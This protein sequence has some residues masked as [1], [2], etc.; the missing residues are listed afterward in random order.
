MR[1][2]HCCV[3]GG[4]GFLGR[5]LL[6]LLVQSGREIT[7]IGRSQSPRPPLPKSVRYIVGD[8]GEKHFLSA[9][10]KGV[11]EVVN[12]AYQTNPKSS[13]DKPLTDL[14]YNL[15]SFLSF[16]QVASRFSMVK[17]VVVSSGG[18]VYGQGG[19][20]PIT[21]D[22]PTNPIS[23]YGVSKLALEKYALMFHKEFAL[24]VV[25]VRPGNAFGEGQKPFTGQGFIATALGCI[26]TGRPVEIFGSEGT[27]RDYI[28]VSDVASGILRA[29]EHGTP[30]G[31]YNIG[32]GVGRSNIDVLNIIGGLAPLCNRRWEIRSMPSRKFDVTANVLDSTKLKSES[33]WQVT[34]PFEEGLIRT[35]NWLSQQLK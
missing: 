23:P 10:L 15:P 35:R 19:C 17:L 18:A 11:D 27:I 20:S 8:Y 30:G 13:H 24:P 34:V 29:L 33:D 28:H 7:V 9:A 12:L 32:A 2:N 16:L 3:I 4:T 31:C 14:T 26:L 1:R 5:C 21:E 22:H 25:C 6:E